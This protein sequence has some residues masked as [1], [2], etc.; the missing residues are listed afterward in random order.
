MR[1][2]FLRPALLS[3]ILLL[4]DGAAHC[5]L[6]PHGKS[7]VLENE[8]PVTLEM[9]LDTDSIDEVYVPDDDFIELETSDST[10]LYGISNLF[11][12][13]NSLYVHSEYV[14]RVFDLSGVYLFDDIE[15]SRIKGRPDYYQQYDS[16]IYFM[17]QNS[18]GGPYL[19]QF[20][21]TT[22]QTRMFHFNVKNRNFE[23]KSFFKIKDGIAYIE[24]C[25]IEDKTKNPLLFKLKLSDLKTYYE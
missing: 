14:V 6:I 25:D 8:L 11:V 16:C 2:Y 1:T 20:D 3:V 12:I 4:G 21:I 23:Q 24:F 18:A 19:C 13:D 22:R 7:P 17:R 15:R 10:M 9:T 5:A